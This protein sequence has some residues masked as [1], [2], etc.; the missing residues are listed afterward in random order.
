M[1]AHQTN[2]RDRVVISK[3]LLEA[4]TKEEQLVTA[5]QAQ[6]ALAERP[7]LQNA[8]S[9]HLLVTRDQ[10]TA[11]RRRIAEIGAEESSIPGLAVAEAVV[12]LV[13]TVA[14]KGL[15]LAKG[16]LQALRGT[17]PADNELRN[18][19][20]CYWNEAE[21]IAHYRV[22]ETVAEQL[23]DHETAEL[24]RAHRAEEEAMQRTLEGLLPAIVRHVVEIESP[25]PVRD[26]R[27]EPTRAAAAASSSSA[28]SATASKTSS[29][30]SA[31]ATKTTSTKTTS[32][33]RRGSHAAGD[34]KPTPS[35]TPAS[36][37]A[38]STPRRSTAT[39]AKTARKPAPATN[40]PA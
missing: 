7:G 16:P 28:A 24:A 30:T 22:I 27:P 14:N 13:G 39:A 23:G 3:Y 36:L 15:A 20:D 11:L 40:R 35:S 37:R 9:D 18:V 2:D 34:G 12:G 25:D 32:T 5:L 38:K 1:T 4:L 31:R 33:K 21:E 6:I 29:S 8:L 19:R 10:V 26:R 17:S